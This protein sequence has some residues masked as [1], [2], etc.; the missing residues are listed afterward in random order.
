MTSRPAPSAR[1]QGGWA[2]A[3]TG[4]V[5]ALSLVL[6]EGG[7]LPYACPFHL[8]T[9]LPCATCGMTRGFVALAHG[10]WH[11]ALDLNLASPL[12]FALA[13]LTLVLALAQVALDRPVLKS[14]WTRHRT[15]LLPLVTAVLAISW[16][17]RLAGAWPRG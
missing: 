8:I 3:V 14:A 9:G 1:R 17:L 15:W 12:L 13:C 5:L 11:R 7:S 4:G 16:G 2:A 6:R 10:Q